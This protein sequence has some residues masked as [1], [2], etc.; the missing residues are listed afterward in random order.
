MKSSHLR[1]EQFLLFRSKIT[2]VVA[3]LLRLL[4]AQVEAVKVGRI[5]ASSGTEAFCQTVTF[6][7]DHTR[8]ETSVSLLY[9]CLYHRP[10]NQ[11]SYF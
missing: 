9:G 6:T 7:L 10:F 11:P 4:I 8:L 3:E 1:Q 5:A 2:A